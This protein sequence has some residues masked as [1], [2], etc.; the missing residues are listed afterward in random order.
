MR[1]TARAGAAI[2]LGGRRAAL[3]AAAA[4]LLALSAAPQAFAHSAFADA[5]REPGARLARAP[6]NV[7]LDFTESLNRGLSHATLVNVATGKRVPTEIVSRSGRSIV[8][9][10]HRTLGR[11]PYRVD[12]QAVATT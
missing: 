3:V 9:R 4:T 2:R 6:Q 11:A 10:P 12:W 5:Q 1:D 7:R 8:I